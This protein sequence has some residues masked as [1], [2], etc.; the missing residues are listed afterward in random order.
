LGIWEVSKWV[1]RKNSRRALPFVAK[2]FR[3]IGLYP[4]NYFIMKSKAGY[5]K[6]KKT[7]LLVGYA[8]VFF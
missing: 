4:Q 2:F 7:Y 6:I 8:C 3:K 1:R 5:L